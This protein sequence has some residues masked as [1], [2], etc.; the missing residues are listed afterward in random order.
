MNY[1][2]RNHDKYELNLKSYVD[3]ILFS[4]LNDRK[5]ELALMRVMGAG[6]SKL[7]LLIILEG[8]L[9]ALLG[10]I[11]GYI[12]SH[13]GME[14]I[15]HYAK[16]R[17]RYSL[18]VFIFLKDEMIIFTISLLIGIVAALIPAFQAYR[19]DIHETIS[20]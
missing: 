15:A 13:V 1:Q 12:I 10:F 19:T 6:H 8:V 20:K 3:A 7:F 2:I 11:V 14:V 4:S 17:N 9:L 18:T 16:A 5:Y